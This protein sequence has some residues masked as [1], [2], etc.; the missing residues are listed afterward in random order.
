MLGRRL[1]DAL[2][3]ALAWGRLRVPAPRAG[4]PPDLP[5]PGLFY[6]AH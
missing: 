2:E 4:L 3:S 1:T 6:L 5:E